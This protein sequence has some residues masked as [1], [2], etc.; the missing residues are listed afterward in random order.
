M[1]PNSHETIRPGALIISLDFEL[2]WGLLNTYPLRA[3]ENRLLGARRAVTAFLDLFEK[4]EIHATWA[5]V[6]LLFFRTK[7]ELLDSLPAVRPHG[8]GQSVTPYDILE[9]VGPDERADPY[10]FAHSLTER[11]RRTKSQELATHTFSHFV[12]D[13]SGAD[14]GIAFRSDLRAA[15]HTAGSQRESIASIVFPQNKYYEQLLEI[16]EE[17]GIH[18]F[19]GKKDYW[20][21]FLGSGGKASRAIFRGLRLLD[22]HVSI[23]GS[24]TFTW[25][26]IHNVKPYNIGESWPLECYTHVPWLAPLE[27]LRLKRIKKSLN[28]AAKKQE[29]FHLWWHP[30][31]FG[32]GLRR[33]LDFL[34]RILD[35]FQGLRKSHGMMSLNMREVSER[36]TH[37]DGSHEAIPQHV[38]SKH[39]RKT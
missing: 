33:N 16:A 19:R 12:W 35:H 4:Y 24:N 30:H 37:F 10:H 11:I 26:S 23:S 3:I 22:H 25:D 32:I 9:T 38:S 31:Q 29:L 2:H 17:E 1:K 27:P 6:G 21:T 36:V 13:Y 5:V 28:R 34:E 15:L 18:A 20:Y 7:K 8:D 14:D 39:L